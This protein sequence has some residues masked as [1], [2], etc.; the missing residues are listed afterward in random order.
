MTFKVGDRV[1]Q[2]KPVYKSCNNKVGVAVREEFFLS[3]VV[4]DDPTDVWFFKKEELELVT[5]PQGEFDFG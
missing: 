4:F 3:V 5:G 1:R 2:K